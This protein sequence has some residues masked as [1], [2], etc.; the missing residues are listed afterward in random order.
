MS[1]LCKTRHA[2]LYKEPSRVVRAKH[3]S[4]VST[5]TVY[6]TNL[7]GRRDYQPSCRNEELLQREVTC[8]HLQNCQTA[9]RCELRQSSW[10][11]DMVL[12]APYIVVLMLVNIG[13]AHEGCAPKHCVHYWK[14]DWE[15]G[16]VWEEL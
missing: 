16:K 1:F 6:V 12:T 3:C 13:K 10:L 9:E 2:S 11:H 5:H 14:V 7:V 4:R 15:V 8:S